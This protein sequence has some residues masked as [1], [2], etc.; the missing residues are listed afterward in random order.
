MAEL[1]KYWHMLRKRYTPD[2]SVG[3]GISIIAATLAG[4]GSTSLSVSFRPMKVTEGD[5]N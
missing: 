2:L 5:L 1:L 3:V 4:L